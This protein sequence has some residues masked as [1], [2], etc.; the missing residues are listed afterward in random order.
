MEVPGVRKYRFLL[1]TAAGDAV[2]AA[3]VEALH[4]SDHEVRVAVLDAVREAFVAGERVSPDDSSAV[5]RLV[6]SGERRSPGAFLAVCERAALVALA[7]RVVGASATS[8]LFQGYEQWDGAEPEPAYLGV[9]HGGGPG[10][11]EGAQAAQIKA[12]LGARILINNGGS[13]NGA[14]G[15]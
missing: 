12:A 14:G 7:E 3:H 6:V 8:G 1:R 15:G 2:E 10:L 9:D 11:S 4:R 5:A 13:L